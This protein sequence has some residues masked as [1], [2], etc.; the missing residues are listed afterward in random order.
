MFGY[1]TLIGSHFDKYTIDYYNYDEDTIDA[2]LF[3]ITDGKARRDRHRASTC[4][5]VAG[6]DCRDFPDSDSVH[7]T[8]RVLFN[9]MS[10]YINRAGDESLHSALD[11]FKRKH[12]YQYKDEHEHQHRLKIFR[13]NIRSI[14][15]HNRAAL[16]YKM[17]LNKF[18]DR[19]VAW[20]SPTL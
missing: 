15:T 19:T 2:S 7:P 5:F 13:N 8:A 4:P 17:K 9:P 18:A 16:T 6:M 14:N 10:E 20:T 12:G 3:R 1:D 11:D